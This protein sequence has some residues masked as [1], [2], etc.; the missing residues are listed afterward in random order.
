MEVMHSIK[1]I[2]RIHI[3]SVNN[4]WKT[5]KS[6]NLKWPSKS[7]DINLTED[8]WKMISDSVYDGSQFKTKEILINKIDNVINHINCFKTGVFNPNPSCIENIFCFAAKY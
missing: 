1:M 6:Q 4:F 3:A 7:P 8:V 2:H 5:S